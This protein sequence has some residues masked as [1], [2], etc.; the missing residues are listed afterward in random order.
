MNPKTQR[1]ITVG[2]TTWR[3]MVKQGYLEGRYK[4][5]NELEDLPQDEDEAKRRIKELDEQLPRHY[6]AVRGRG[7]YQDKI[8]RRSRDIRP[9]DVSKMAVKAAT[10]ALSENLDDLVNA[11][12]GM[13]AMLERLILDEMVS[14]GTPKLFK[15]K[16][17]TNKR[18]RVAKE[19]DP[20][21]A[22]RGDYDYSDSDND[23]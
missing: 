6:Q 5:P 10:R 22:E 18:W 4:N 13:E 17:T 15:P 3:K 23:W 20:I 12:D 7:V 21:A 19:A 2:G 11:G 9:E 1:M 14:T 16:K 8:V